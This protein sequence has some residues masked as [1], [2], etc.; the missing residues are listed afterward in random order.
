MFRF[1]EDVKAFRWFSLELRA[2]NHKIKDLKSIGAEM[3]ATIFNG[4]KIHNPNLGSFISMRYLRK[5]MK[6]KLWSYLKDQSNSCWKIKI[7]KENPKRHLRRKW[8]YILRVWFSKSLRWVWFQ[9]QSGISAT[10]MGRFNSRL[11]QMVFGKQKEI[12][13]RKRQQVSARWHQRSWALLPI[14]HQRN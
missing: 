7:Q 12:I 9:C 1:T 3:E 14:R 6:K 8:R 10:K 5:E 11:L 13:R 4:F 2:G